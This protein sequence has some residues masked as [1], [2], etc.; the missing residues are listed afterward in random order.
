MSRQLCP[1]C[2]DSFDAAA[3][4]A[5]SGESEKSE[6]L[7]PACRARLAA[8]PPPPPA[9]ER[10]AA[11][12]GEAGT[13]AAPAAGLL[14]R[15]VADARDWSTGRS[16]LWRAPLLA[17]FGWILAGHLRDSWRDPEY[18][19]LFSGINLGIHELGHYVFAFDG[20]FLNL[21]GGTL[22]QCLAPVAAGALLVV[23]Q[24]DYFGAV[25][26]LAWLATNFFGIAPYAADARAEALP[27][28]SP[29][30]GYII[31]DWHYLLGRLGL[32]AH[33]QQIGLCFR[34]AGTATMLLALALGGWLLGQM[35]RRRKAEP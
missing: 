18:W 13:E 2:R 10:P 5:A 12:A 27:L 28:V 16:W 33:D 34:A 4:P 17:W 29:G 35:A 24:R 7:C 11:G 32:L 21:A 3:L 20:E 1:V 26:C 19:S 6:A 8:R 15:L 30:G 23:K 14:A 22:L 9:P 25:V 31:H